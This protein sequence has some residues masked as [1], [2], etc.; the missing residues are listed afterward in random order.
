MCVFNYRYANSND[1]SLILEFIKE[2]AIYEKMQDT[3]VA[4]EDLIYEWLFE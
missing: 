3:V 4:N 2:L 1:V